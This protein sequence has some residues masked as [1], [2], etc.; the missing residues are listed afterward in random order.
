[1]LTTIAKRLISNS[2]EHFQHELKR[3]HFSRLIRN[4]T[5][6]PD[7]PEMKVISEVVRP[8]DWVIDVGANV[9]HYTLHLANC[10]GDRGRVFAFEPLQET[11]SLLSANVHAAGKR[12]VTL[13]NAAVSTAVH[14]AKMSVPKFE[15]NGMNNLYRAQIS[16]SGDHSIFCMPLDSMVPDSHRIRLIKI[17]AE[18]HDLQV[19]IGA[20]HLLHAHKPTII[21]EAQE[22]GQIADWLSDRG[23]TIT[24]ATPTS[25]NITARPR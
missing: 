23:Y 7:E 4:G 9:G 11:F 3:L 13:I 8:G 16:S 19:L 20:S 21:V 15:D 5:F 10:A 24:K 1:M 25:P 14:E 2:P 18:G 12:N 22:K 6:I 17:D